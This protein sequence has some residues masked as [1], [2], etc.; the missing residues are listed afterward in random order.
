MMCM[1][2]TFDR[3]CQ[4]NNARS[5]GFDGHCCHGNQSS[6]EQRVERFASAVPKLWASS[7]PTPGAP[8][9]GISCT[10][11]LVPCRSI[12]WCQLHKMVTSCPWPLGFGLGTHGFVRASWGQCQKNQTTNTSIAICYVHSSVT[13]R[14]LCSMQLNS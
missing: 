3:C 11:G 9:G 12:N 8:T 14:V 2:V 10:L 4:G 13:C 1:R 5:V 6:V 7:I